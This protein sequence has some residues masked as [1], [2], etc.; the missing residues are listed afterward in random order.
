MKVLFFN[1]TRI[2]TNPGCHATVNGLINFLNEYL[3]KPSVEFIPLGTEYDLFKKDRFIKR[4]K[5]RI[6]LKKILVKLN[7][8]SFF[9][10]S[11]NYYGID[12]YKWKRKSLKGLSKEIRCKINNADLVIINM[13][14][15]IHHDSIGALTLLGIA[16]YSK[17]IG[18]KVA[19][20][21]GSYQDINQKLTDAILPKIDFLSVRELLSYEYLKKRNIKVNL[22]PDF[23]FRVNLYNE[24]ASFK[25][26]FNEGKYCL[27]T[28]GVLAAYPNQKGSISIDD[29]KHHIKEIRIL[30]YKPVFLKIE[31]SEEFIEKELTK[32]DVSCISYDDGLNYS[33][34]GTLLK[35]FD[36]LITG[37]YHIGIFGLINK[38][39]TY[40]FK[41]NTYKI[42]GMLKMLQVSDNIILDDSVLDIKN[43]TEIIDYKLP[44]ESSFTSFKEFLISL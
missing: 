6:L 23:A 11:K 36:L 28:P 38:T 4:T 8:F 33:N 43:R 10:S 1:D 25:N 20:V 42:E 31:E 26:R 3:N 12:F 18:K 22:I 21:N 9:F 40:F 14:G 29:I 5:L 39:K 44:T 2:E 37:R 19:L 24:N 13:E 27:Y 34:I 35:S 17:S 16:L 41:S 32:L 7:V 15:T 30:G